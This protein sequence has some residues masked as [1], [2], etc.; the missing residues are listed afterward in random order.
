MGHDPDA[1]VASKETLATAQQ[2]W[3]RFL[4]RTVTTTALMAASVMA[5]E[6]GESIRVIGPGQQ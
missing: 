1:V 4:C 5:I 3:R 2:V 6:I